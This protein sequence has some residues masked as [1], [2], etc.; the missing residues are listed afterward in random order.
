MRFKKKLRKHLEATFELNLAPMMDMMVTIIPFMLLS[1]VFMQLMIIDV[2]LPQPVAKA[3]EEDRNKKE[4]DVSVAVNLAKSGQVLL[5]IT[6]PGG[7]V[8][9]ITVPAVQNEA[10]YKTVHQKLVEVKVNHPKV[11]RMELNPEDGIPYKNIVAMMDASRML[12]K[13]DPKVMIE[14]A[15][16]KEKAETNLLF[17]DVVLA[18]LMGN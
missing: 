7:R 9:K 2:P 10:D 5:V 4:R 18:N 17:P 1:A 16:K 11:F 12:D 13:T 3:I 6:E 14:D 15:E 8:N